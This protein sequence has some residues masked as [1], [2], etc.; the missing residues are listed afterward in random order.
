DLPD[1]LPGHDPRFRDPREGP[2]PDRFL[3]APPARSVDQRQLRPW[4]AGCRASPGGPRRG[5]GPRMKTF[6]LALVL[7]LPLL[8]LQLALNVADGASP[9]PVGA[10]GVAG[11]ACGL[12]GV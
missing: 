8:I 6:R 7:G 5:A 4:P 1:R 3:P 9:Y 11:L 10:L 12:A 2:V